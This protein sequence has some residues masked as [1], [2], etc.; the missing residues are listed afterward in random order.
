MSNYLDNLNWRY[1]TKKFD[2][3]KKVSPEKLESLL[4]AISLSASSYGLQ[5]Y[6]IFVIED[7]AVREKLKPAAWG[8]AQITDSSHVIVLAHQS[9]FGEELVDNY[10]EK[11]S[12]TRNIPLKD[13][14][15]YAD[16]M[17][18]KLVTLPESEKASWTA[19]QAYLALGNLLS[20]AADL[21]IDSCPME[22]FDAPD[23]NEILGLT[24]KGLNAA[25]LVA[26]GHRSEEDTTQHNKK[27]RKP[28][29]ELI[30][31]I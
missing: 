17:K 3:T 25:V 11:V 19:R 28:K 27:V 7:K 21:K 29:K 14:G 10:L 8:Q 6:E 9:T 24:E 26:I 1:A 23:V 15:G 16:F 13:L 30:T 2:T 31:H 22:G 4:D 20:A 5:P 18:S 12:A